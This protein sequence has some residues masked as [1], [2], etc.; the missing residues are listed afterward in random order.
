[1][2]RKKKGRSEK[3]LGTL[4]KLGRHWHFRVTIDGVVHRLATKKKE[5]EDAKE[6]RDRFLRTLKASN[7]SSRLSNLHESVTVSDLVDDYIQHLT[8]NNA[9]SLVDIMHSLHA[10]RSA[11]IFKGRLAASITT[12]DL[13]NYRELR[14]AQGKKDATINNEFA[15]LRSAFNHGMKRQT[16]KK[17]LDVPYFPIVK[18]NNVRLGFIEASEYKQILGYMCDSLKPFFVLAYH[19]GCRKSEL[20][21]LRWEQVDRSLRV[22]QLEPGTTKND[23]GRYLPFYGDMEAWLDEQEA[24]RKAQCPGCEYVLFWQ[25]SDVGYPVKLQVGDRLRDFDK[26]WKRA[27]NQA[28]FPGLLPHDLRRSAVRNM[29]QGAGIPEGQ[30]MKISGHKT[31]SM[32]ERYNIVSLKGVIESGKKMDEWMKAAKALPVER[33]VAPQLLSMKQRVRALKGQGRTI[34]GIA[35]ELGISEATVYYHLS[36]ATRRKKAS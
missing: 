14:K 16:P 31:H 22:I 25:Q 30:A 29:T 4:T 12:Q 33:L 32:L 13:T 23:E 11:D 26:M 19:S 7:S 18:V 24:I 36:D 3:G 8:A 1:M 10:M 9:K 5:I 17:V 6:E 2:A 28:G 34:N 35:T 20:T 27:V 15:Y 21:N